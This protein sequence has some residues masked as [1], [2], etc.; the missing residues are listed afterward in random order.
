MA[1]SPKQ[2]LESIPN[3]VKAQD[4]AALVT[5]QDHSDK[6]VRK[7]ARK[8]IHKLRS[9]GVEIPDAATARAWQTGSLDDLRGELEPTAMVDLMG[10]PGMTRIMLTLPDPDSR[11]ILVLCTL[12]GADQIADF[13]GY[14]QTD[15][16][17]TRLTRDWTRRFPNR[18]VPVDW[19]KARVRWGRNQTIAG[20]NPVSSDLNDLL[21]QLGDDPSERPKNFIGELLADIEA[22]PIADK[23]DALLMAAGVNRWP[24]VLD[25]QPVLEKV[26]EQKPDLDQ[27]T[28]ETER[29]SLL[30]EN[31]KGNE[32]IRKSLAGAV[33]N[34]LDDAAIGLWLDEKDADAKAVLELATQLR[35]SDTPEQLPWVVR[36]YGMQIFSTLMALSQQ[37]QIPENFMDMARQARAS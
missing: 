36:L 1:D 27:E 34:L 26:N 9:R 21:E 19:A 17:R 31:A 7:A 20:G 6:K 12:N 13:G 16:Q 18:K 11:G 33:A 2:I 28:P 10:M 29:E 22:T 14:V 8:A 23:T 32:E 4:A 25:M 30:M 3:L 24:P 37:G 15:G 35:Q 5:L